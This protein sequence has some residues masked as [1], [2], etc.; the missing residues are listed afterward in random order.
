MATFSEIQITFNTVSE[1]N[2]TVSFMID[3]VNCFERFVLFRKLQNEITLDGFSETAI[4][5]A[6][7]F[8]T[9]FN[10]D[11]NLLNEF[12]IVRV[13]GQVTIKAKNSNVQFSEADGSISNTADVT[14]LITNFNSSILEVDSISFSESDTDPCNKVKVTIGTNVLITKVSG[15]ISI[16]PNVNNPFS[17][18]VD[19]DLEVNIDLESAD[20]QLGYQKIQTPQKLLIENVDSEILG[21]I[22]NSIF[23]DVNNV[24]GLNLTYSLDD[25]SYNS[26]NTLNNLTL[27]TK[28][29]YVK[30]GLGCKVQKDVE[31]KS[32]I[33]PETI[34]YKEPHF[35]M[36]EGNSIRLV[37]K[38]DF[39]NCANYKNDSNTLS[40]QEFASN[41]N[42]IY[43]RQH[44]FQGCDN[45]TIGF[46]SNYS[47]IKAVIIN[48]CDQERNVPVTKKTNY[49]GLKDR[50]DAFSYD[51]GDGKMGIFFNGLG[52][53]YNY[54]T[55]NVITTYDLEGKLP[56]FGY[57]FNYIKILNKWFLIEDVIYDNERESEVLVIEKVYIG[58]PGT[59][60]LVTISSIYD[61][62]NF[63]VY[64]F[65]IDMGNYLNKTITVRLNNKDSRFPDLINVS[66]LINIKDHQENTVYI[67][68]WDEE[69]TDINYQ[70]GLRNKLRL[71]INRI[72]S[73]FLDETENN[74]TDTRI[75]QLKSKL[76]KKHTYTFE[77]VSEG[78]MSQAVKILSNAKIKI[79]NIP[80]VKESID[81]SD[82][83]GDTNLYIIKATMIVSGNLTARQLAKIPKLIQSNNAGFIKYIEY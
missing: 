12:E 48:H 79:M 64:Q 24:N 13:A 15:D 76:Y 17:F 60:S 20:G 41:K 75:V 8:I 18:D 36:P 62:N 65:D 78:I 29:L 30:D 54:E 67:E 19:R 74:K 69:N 61:L 72:D 81:V 6:A 44:L 47:D 52:S 1:I 9:S 22:N 38:I 71:K 70:F 56:P 37:N 51:L 33:I 83:K 59:D 14:F 45:V 40:H 58:G 34:R 82:A 11:Y 39:D 66:E 28:T 5:N 53:I 2:R 50:R 16:D 7:N 77:P 42:L 63:E 10:L 3:D 55:G 31:V 46:E 68:S 80:H 35:F 43:Q 26:E 25:A 49:I 27:G 73:G 32:L 57:E 4:A 21:L 23:V